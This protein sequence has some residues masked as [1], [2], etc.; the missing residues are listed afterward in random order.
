MSAGIATCCNRG[1]GNLSQ[2]YQ[3]KDLA[4]ANGWAPDGAFQD[5]IED[6]SN[7]AVSAAH[8]RMPSGEGLPDCEECGEPIPEARRSITDR[9]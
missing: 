7:D 1:L 9:R 3:M 2:V 8:A 6:S 4:M 5:Q